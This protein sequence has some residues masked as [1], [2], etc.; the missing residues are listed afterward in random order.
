MGD[1]DFNSHNLRLKNVCLVPE[2]FTNI[3]PRMLNCKVKARKR[4]K[5]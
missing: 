2:C 1:A 3:G 5:I 4:N